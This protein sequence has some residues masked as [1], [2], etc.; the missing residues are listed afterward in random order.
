MKYIQKQLSPH[1]FIAW[2][3]A[4]ALDAEGQPMNWGYADMPADL[5]DIVKESLIQEQGGLC[6]YT[7][8]AITFRNS[9][10][11][12]LKPQA[13]CVNHEDTN[14][15]NLLAAYP[16]PT[17]PQC[18]YGAHA[19]A[20]WYDEYL[21]VHPLRSD[22][23]HRFRYKSNGKIAPAKPDDAGA[24]ETIAH[25]YLDCDELNGL[26]EAAIQ[27]ALFADKSL[28]QGQV[29]RLMAAMDERDSNGCFRK[30]CFVIKQA[31]KKYLKRRD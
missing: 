20:D 17:A 21:F 8:R 3:H 6:C 27:E 13:S 24:K 31:C 28:S 9:H 11:E 29:E 12:H 22:C 26:R 25:L 30:F 5:R 18:A 16:A 4:K 10:I 19:K 2:T 1:E 7:G 14:Y 23:E 15:T